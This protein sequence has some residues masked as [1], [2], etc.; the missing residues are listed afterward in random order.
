[1]S[2]SRGVGVLVV[3][4]VCLIAPVA[5][6][7][8]DVRTEIAALAE[9]WE[10]RFNSGDIAGVAALYAEDGQLLPPGS[11]IV[12]GRAAIQQFWQGAYDSGMGKVKFELLEVHG[13]G[14]EAV[15]VGRYTVTNAQ[16]QAVERGKYI[17]L[18]KKIAGSWQ[19][20]RDIWNSSEAPAPA[21]SS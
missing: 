10:A 9:Q 4:L 15:E 16:G 13:T 12:T 8:A 1:M 20:Y 2:S 7:A 3:A 21:P 6:A 17:V 14:S 5:L 19:L 18:W 11:D